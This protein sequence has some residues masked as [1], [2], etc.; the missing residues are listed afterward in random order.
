MLSQK[1]SRSLLIFLMN[2]HCQ[3]LRLVKF[4]TRLKVRRI[5]KKQS[6]IGVVGL[7]VPEVSIVDETLAS[8]QSFMAAIKRSTT[9]TSHAVMVTVSNQEVSMISPANH[10]SASHH[11]PFNQ[12]S[13]DSDQES[14]VNIVCPLIVDVIHPG[15]W[16]SF[17]IHNVRIV[18]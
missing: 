4:T 16:H 6:H 10:S 14:V 3:L 15:S 12:E 1:S 13:L 5:A 11:L 9:S 7:Q 17:N 2:P 18:W 8:D